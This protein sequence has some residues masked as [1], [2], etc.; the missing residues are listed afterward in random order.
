MTT[1]DAIENADRDAWVFVKSRRASSVRWPTLR[2]YREGTGFRLRSSLESAEGEVGET[3]EVHCETPLDVYRAL[4]PEDRGIGGYRRVLIAQA[5]IADPTFE[6]GI[7][8]VWNEIFYVPPLAEGGL[9]NGE[10]LPHKNDRAIRFVGTVL[11]EGSSDVSL[12]DRSE[13]ARLWALSGRGTG[14]LLCRDKMA[15]AP[16]GSMVLQARHITWGTTLAEVVQGGI[17]TETGWVPEAV[18]GALEQARAASAAVRLEM[19]RSGA[20]EYARKVI[21]PLVVLRGSQTATALLRLEK[22][23]S[24]QWAGGQTDATWSDGTIFLSRPMIA[25]ARHRLV[26]QVPDG[27]WEIAPAGREAIARGFMDVEDD[28]DTDRDA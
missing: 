14:F 23:D 26:Q 19:G 25:L 13:I 2:L 22:G 9:C 12:G 28:G 7:E 8:P 24:L 18:A 16:D 11:G 17:F 6:R 3:W 20:L 15:Q 21:G 1:V 10:T 5:C 27:R 4:A